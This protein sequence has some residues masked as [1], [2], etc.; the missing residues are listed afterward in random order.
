ML[1]GAFALLMFFILLLLFVAGAGLTVGMNLMSRDRGDGDDS[2]TTS[3]DATPFPVDDDEPAE[4]PSPGDGGEPKTP[5]DTQTGKPDNDSKKKTSDSPTDDDRTPANGKSPSVNGSDPA[6][7]SGQ[8]PANAGAPPSSGSNNAGKPAG[9]KEY[10]VAGGSFFGLAPE[11][12][13]VVYVLDCSGSMDGAPFQRATSE[14]LRSVASLNAS[15]AYYVIFFSDSSV[16]MYSPDVQPGLVSAND[17]NLKKL[18]E[19]V[20]KFNAAGGTEP[21]N[22]LLHALELNP[23]TI[24]F[25]TD[26]GFDPN[27]V[28]ELQQANTKKVV[29]N[30]FAFVNRTGELLLKLIADQ[31]QGAYQ[32]IP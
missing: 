10:T 27:V 9:G 4:K 28:D 13:S 23:T 25:L 16:P 6:Q 14:L 2:V 17:D 3:S 30:T 32:F 7:S 19:W 15:Q 31:N 18:K 11:G 5:D 20:A 24:F 21:R 1:V 29:V 8:S 12:D 22:A 26:G